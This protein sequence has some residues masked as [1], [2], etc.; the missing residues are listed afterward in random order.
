LLRQ[1]GCLEVVATVN[2]APRLAGAVAVAVGVSE[3]VTVAACLQIGL[4]PEGLKSRQQGRADQQGGKALAQ[5]PAMWPEAYS[6]GS[7][8]SI[9]VTPRLPS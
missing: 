7:R 2:R 6:I 5:A 9:T 1:A 4:A 8:T 3:A